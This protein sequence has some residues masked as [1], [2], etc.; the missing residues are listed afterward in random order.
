VLTWE[1]ISGAKKYTVY[2][3]TSATGKYKS[4]G[5]T[6]KLTYTHTKATAGTV[7]FYKI[8]ANASSSKYNSPYSNIVDCG[9]NCAAPAVKVSLN[10]SGK[11]ALSWGKV[12]GAVKYEVYK[13]GELLTT[14]TAT[15][16]TDTAAQAGE[17][18]VYTVKAI[19]KVEDYNSALSKE[20]TATATC[21]TP[22]ISGKVGANKK[23]V[24]TWGE[25]EGA[26]KCI[27]YRSTSSSKNYKAIGE[28]TDGLSYEDLT[29]KKSKTYYYKVVAVG[30]GFQSAQS[31]YVKVKSK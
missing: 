31:S 16:Y 26:T 29:A 23:P 19:N 15:G 22:K 14:A 10:S 4:L 24:I 9:A 1:K 20:V 12:T 27:V 8:V 21:A 30:D 17:S 6:T 11:P 25:V 5:T 2:Y 18:C 13:N 28:V 7:Y 3:A